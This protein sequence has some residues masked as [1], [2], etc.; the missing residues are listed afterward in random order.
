MST[1]I[2]YEGYDIITSVYVFGSATTTQDKK[3]RIANSYNG[4]IHNYWDFEKIVK[5]LYI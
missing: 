1:I 2:G 5:N 4:G 3:K